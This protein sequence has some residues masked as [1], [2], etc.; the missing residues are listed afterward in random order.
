ML[1]YF[2]SW[3]QW[4]KLGK[5]VGV[6]EDFHIRSMTE[7]MDPIVIMCLPEWTGRFYVKVE[8]DKTKQALTSIE[9]A[10]KK[11]SPDFPFEYNFLDEAFNKIYKEEQVISKLSI[12]FTIMAILISALGLLGLASYSTER[13]K[14]EISIRKVLGASVPNLIMFMSTEF[15]ILTLV[16]LTIG[17]PV[18]YYLMNEF[19]RGY[20]YHVSISFTIFIKAA[21]GLLIITLGVILYQVSRAAL[22]NPVDNLRNE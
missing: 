6:V 17:C 14:K 20:A 4:G 3:H 22:N 9:Q 7:T 18:A 10:W 12:G 2:Q 11:A 8:A 15:I 13:K 1:E 16:A 21:V 5:V 19:L